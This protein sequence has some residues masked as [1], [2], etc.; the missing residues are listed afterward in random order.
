M[1]TDMEVTVVG[2]DPVTNREPFMWFRSPE[3]SDAPASV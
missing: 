1:Y 2:P 3:S